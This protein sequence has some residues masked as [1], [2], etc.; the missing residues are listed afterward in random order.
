KKPSIRLNI[1]NF[2]FNQKSQDEFITFAVVIYNMPLDTI[3]TITTDEG[4]NA[5]A[6]KTFQAQFHENVVY[7]EFCGH[8]GKNVSS[9]KTIEEIPFLPIEFFKSKKVIC[10]SFTPQITFTSSGT[11]GSEVSRHSV[12]SVAL[13]ENSYLTAFRQFYGDI[14]DYC[15]LALLP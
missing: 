13:Y 10:G 1:A 9:V 2:H 15:V 5:M 6:L 4:F 7:R 3:F 11:T 8:I 14:E 12:K